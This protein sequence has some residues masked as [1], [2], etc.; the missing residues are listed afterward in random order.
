MGAPPF[1]LFSVPRGHTKHACGTAS[2]PV[3]DDRSPALVPLALAGRPRRLPACAPAGVFHDARYGWARQRATFHHLP[4][5]APVGSSTSSPVPV[6]AA[7]LDY[8]RDDVMLLTAAAAAVPLNHSSDEDFA[9]AWPTITVG[10]RADV[11][12][13][14]RGSM[15]SGLVACD[16]SRRTP[17]GNPFK[18]GPRGDA[19]HLAPAVCHAYS[20]LLA[21]PELDAAAIGSL[22]PGVVLAPAGGPC[23]DASLRA[24]AI[25]RLVSLVDDG[26][27]LFLTCCGLEDCHG[28]PLGRFV[29][30]MSSRSPAAPGVGVGGGTRGDAVDPVACAAALLASLSPPGLPPVPLPSGPMPAAL[31]LPTC[32]PA[33]LTLAVR[34]SSA[35]EGRLFQP[36]AQG[37]R[38]FRRALAALSLGRQDCLASM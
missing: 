10:S 6:P 25:G 27:K 37:C 22:T 17:M 1:C 36:A 16:I 38:P 15:P 13:W 20:R 21:E 29:M 14:G 11:H 33:P 9:A 18:M 24:E 23:R 2:A 32:P 8:P 4:P 34:P 5:Q 7:K 35:V 3:W 26:A 28:I 30:A 12:G 31:P 19:Y